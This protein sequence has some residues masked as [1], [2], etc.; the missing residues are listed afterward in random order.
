MSRRG[1]FRAFAGN[2]ARDPRDA[3]HLFASH[4][5]VTRDINARSIANGRTNVGHVRPADP[6]DS[7]NLHA[8]RKARGNE[9]SQFRAADERHRKMGLIMVR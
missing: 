7:Q 6:F 9:G 1:V 2:D 5:F 8:R 4:Y 3:I